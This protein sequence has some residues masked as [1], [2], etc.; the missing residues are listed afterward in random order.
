M[1]PLR[2]KVPLKVFDTE[3]D[4][5]TIALSVKDS[6]FPDRFEWARDNGFALE[7]TPDPLSPEK[8]LE[9][10]LPYASKGV[11]VRYHTRFFDFD[12]GNADSGRAEEA[13]HVHMAVLDAMEGL[14]EPVLTVHLNLN[15]RIPFDPGIAVRNLTVLVRYARKKGI[16]VNLENL[17][18]GPSS[19]PKSISEWAAEAG[20]M[21]TMDMGHAVSSDYVKNGTMTVPAIVD[22]FSPMLNE[23]HMYGKEEDRHYPIEDITVLREAIDHLTTTGCRWWTIELDDY[24]EALATRGLL[25][26]YL[27][28]RKERKTQY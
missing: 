20:S 26:E 23:V 9:H 13:L 24:S 15:G 12:L 2:G 17:R 6:E 21:I 18:R 14:G 27:I 5:L 19:N 4:T 22:L 1:K 28:K 7:Y 10:V 16:T 25:L 3:D 8:I 11:P